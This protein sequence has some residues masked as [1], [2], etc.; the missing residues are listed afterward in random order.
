MSG[1]V[2]KQMINERMK[3]GGEGDYELH[4]TKLGTISDI[5][6]ISEKHEQKK[7]AW[8]GACKRVWYNDI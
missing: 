7:G 8:R 3:E 6:S 2:K 5:L 1:K 4:L